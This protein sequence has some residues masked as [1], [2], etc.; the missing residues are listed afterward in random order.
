MKESSQNRQGKSLVVF[1]QVVVRITINMNL[2]NLKIKVNPLGLLQVQERKVNME[3]LEVKILQNSGI[4]MMRNLVKV[5]M[6]HTLKGR[7]LTPPKQLKRKT[8]KTKNLQ[9]NKKL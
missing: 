5:V 2:K 7:L 9:K 1:N 8:A 4:I 3:V 6:I